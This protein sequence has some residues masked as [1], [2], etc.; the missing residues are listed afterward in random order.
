MKKWL[1]DTDVLIDFL[2]GR[3]EAVSFLEKTM[4]ILLFYF[5]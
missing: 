2:R 4:I 1:F 5:Q 3:D